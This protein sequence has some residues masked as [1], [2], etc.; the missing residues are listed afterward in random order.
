MENFT[1]KR[2]FKRLALPIPVELR[3][4][5]ESG[6]KEVNNGICS[7]ISYSG[8][9]IR[10][11]NAG[12]IMPGDNLNISISIPRIFTQEFPFSSLIGKA[13]VVR[14]ERDGIALEFNEDIHRLYV[15][16]A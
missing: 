13:R 15:A 14:V 4:T 1:E 9:Y 8:T 6:K 7:N 16:N 10:N 11:I 12:K 5:L 2:K 3:Q